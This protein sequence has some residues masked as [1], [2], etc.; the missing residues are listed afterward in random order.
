MVTF[1][2]SYWVIAGI[3]A[4]IIILAASFS[5]YTYCC[6]E[7]DCFIKG[8]SAEERSE[9][10][11]HRTLNSGWRGYRARRNFTVHTEKALLA[12]LQK[13]NLNL[14]LELEASQDEVTRLKKPPR[15]L[16][17]SSN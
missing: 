4:G 7:W 17:R 16:L 3:I 10:E 15:P 5:V 9:L 13:Q 1:T 12:S 11:L 14:R 6:G 8:H 2:L